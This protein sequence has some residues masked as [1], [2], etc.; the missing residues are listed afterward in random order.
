MTSP[1]PAP[2]RTAERRDSAAPAAPDERRE[3]RDPRERTRA[4]LAWFALAAV[5]LAADL[6]SKHE[7]F[8][9]HVL[10]PHFREGMVVGHVAAWWRTILV[11]NQGVTFGMLADVPAWS[12]ALLTG[13]VIVWLGI[14]LWRLP[15]GRKVQATSLAMVVGGAVGNLYD[16]TLRPWV[17]PDTRPGVRDFL[18]WYAPEG[19]ALAA[20]LRERGV[21][22]HWYTSNIADVL[23]VCGVILLAACLLR[24]PAERRTDPP[25]E[26]AA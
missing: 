13:A 24:E 11:Y 7:V 5:L 19:T 1:A 18:D 16:R 12:K 14:T 23:I 6:W 4:K 21:H 8:Y 15:P 20:W 9:P 26:A 2:D 22:P 17:E 10:S 25:P 3:Y